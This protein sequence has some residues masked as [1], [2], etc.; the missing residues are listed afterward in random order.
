M[1]RWLLFL[2]WDIHPPI[3]VRV[4]RRFMRDLNE[5]GSATSFFRGFLRSGLWTVY[6]DATPT[7]QAYIASRHPWYLG[8]AKTSVLGVA[9]LAVSNG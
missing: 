7:E 3:Q 5:A 1:L 2:L 6:K 4:F 8:L 9:D